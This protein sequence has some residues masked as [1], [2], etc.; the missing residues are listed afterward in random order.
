VSEAEETWLK[1]QRKAVEVSGRAPEVLRLIGPD[2]KVWGNW[3][4]L[5]ET[6]LEELQQTKVQICEQLPTG[7]H[8]A[9]LV[10]YDNR[11]DQW[12]A[13]PITL[14]GRNAGAHTAAQETRTLQQATSIAVAN[15][16]TAMTAL[17][18]ENQRLQ[19]R[20]DS[21]LEDVSNLV[22]TVI[23][24]QTRNAETEILMKREEE[25]SQRLDMLANAAAP[26]I[27]KLSGVAGDV[28]LRK[29]LEAQN[30]RQQPA[31]GP[32]GGPTTQPVNGAAHDGASKPSSP[33]APSAASG[34]D[35][36]QGSARGP[37]GGNRKKPTRAVRKQATVAKGAAL[38]NVKANLR[39]KKAPKRSRTKPLTRNKKGK[40]K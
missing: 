3:P 19:D 7:K 21:L 22:E 14:A 29:M 10:I 27:G 33:P 6:T 4:I 2:E 13:L 25:R 35:G 15:F 23:D 37:S 28:L 20:V 39:S 26:V 18:N 31:T 38:E 17:R 32:A 9:Q 30:A 1:A 16:E 11:G 40:T 12:S 8:R 24:Y 5:S 36:G 34:A